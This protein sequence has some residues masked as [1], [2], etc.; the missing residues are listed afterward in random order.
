MRHTRNYEAFRSCIADLLA[1][2]DVQSMREITQHVDGVNCLDHSLFVAY[3]SYRICRKLRLDCVSAARGGLLHDM[4]LCDWSTTSV[5]RLRRLLIHPQM[6]LENA[7]QRFTL[8]V[9]EKDIIRKHMWP[10]TF[11]F[12]RYRESW[13]VC[14]ADTGCAIVEMLHIYKKTKMGARMRAL[15]PAIG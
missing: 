2:P 3:V 8:S 14:M 5:S 9:K 13:V 6:A 1:S 4:Y 10:L 12:P 11:R 7:S 15:L